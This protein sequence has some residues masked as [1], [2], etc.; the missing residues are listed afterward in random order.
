M[1]ELDSF[2]RQNL[3]RLKD[4]LFSLQLLIFLSSCS[5]HFFLDKCSVGGKTC[6]IEQ[7]Y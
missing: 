4:L 1:L 6:H 5:V 2:K 3:I 7:A